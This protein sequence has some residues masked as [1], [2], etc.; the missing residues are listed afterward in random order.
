MPRLSVFYGIVVEI[1][2]REHGPPHFHA[3]YA[4]HEA[5]I[6]IRE[7]AIIR[8]SLPR[9]AATMV[10]EWA[11]NHQTELMEAWELCR[12]QRPP[13]QIEPLK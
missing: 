6:D 8:G 2:W 9:R 5:S 3:T 10:V 12:R 4:E 7:L 11:S 13:K 1:Y